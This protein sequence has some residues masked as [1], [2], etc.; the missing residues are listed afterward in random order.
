MVQEMIDCIEEDR[1]H[2][3]SGEEG[4]A[5][6]ELIMA[7]YESQRTGARVKLPLKVRANPLKQMIT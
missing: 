3:S 2:Y 4:R 1:K 6:L 5:A 7:I